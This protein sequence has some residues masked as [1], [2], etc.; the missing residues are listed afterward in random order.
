MAHK[1]KVFK[2]FTKQEL[3]DAMRRTRDDKRYSDVMPE[4]G[5][6]K[7]DWFLLEAMNRDITRRRTPT[8]ILA[9][10][11]GDVVREYVPDVSP[12]TRHLGEAYKSLIMNAFRRRKDFVAHR[13]EP[14]VPAT[15]H[16][17]D[18]S[19]EFRLI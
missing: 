8:I 16:T 13:D 10:L 11:V 5:E 1:E 4:P 9:M 6:L 18:A 14:R 19:G 3:A 12:R 15:E 17:A 2:A 7:I